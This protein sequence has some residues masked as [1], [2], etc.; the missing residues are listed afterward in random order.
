MAEIGQ[1]ETRY[2]KHQFNNEEKVE[3][4]NR[5]LKAE[6]SV[7]EKLAEGETFKQSAKADIARYEGEIA[8]CKEKLRSGYESI[9][10]QCTLK[11]LDGNV[12]YFSKQ[13]GE[14]VDKRPMTEAEQ[15]K[16]AGGFT[17]AEQIIRA[18]SEKQMSEDV[19]NE[20]EE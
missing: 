20:E 17:D 12:V 2:T 9:P 18:D 4:A 16:L 15:M 19:N 5:M 13:T 7:E 1:T 8:G 6:A 3:I 11:Y 14:I 10:I